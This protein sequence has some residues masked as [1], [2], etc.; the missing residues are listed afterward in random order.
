M[1]KSDRIATRREADRRAKPLAKAGARGLDDAARAH[2]TVKA[3]V[4]T[5]RDNRASHT[6]RANAANALLDLG[7]GCAPQSS[8][9]G[10]Q[11]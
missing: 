10:P 7:W 4:A 8:E 3:L 1:A 6:A 9:Q 5:M 2:R 11:A